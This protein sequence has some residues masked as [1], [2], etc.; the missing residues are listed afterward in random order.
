VSDIPLFNGFMASLFIKQNRAAYLKLTQ[1]DFSIIIL[2]FIN[3]SL[4][5]LQFNDVCKRLNLK[6]VS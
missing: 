5:K 4:R 2:C 1:N 6:A 3:K